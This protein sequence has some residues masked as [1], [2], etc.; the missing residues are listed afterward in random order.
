MTTR[1]FPGQKVEGH[2]VSLDQ[3]SRATDRWATKCTCGW[4]AFSHSKKAIIAARES[5]LDGA[6]ETGAAL[7]GGGRESP[8]GP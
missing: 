7:R 6:V 3:V 1:R 8:T 5:H 4:S 2:R